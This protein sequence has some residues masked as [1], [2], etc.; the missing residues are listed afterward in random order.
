[1]EVGPSRTADD[2]DGCRNLARE[3]EHK[4]EQKCGKDA[5]AVPLHPAAARTARDQRAEVGHGTDAEEDDGRINR[6]LDAPDRTPTAYR[7]WN[8]QPVR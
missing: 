3:A 1:M 8:R 2:G 4:R 6:M 7:D 5:E